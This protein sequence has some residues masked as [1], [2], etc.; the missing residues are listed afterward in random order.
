MNTNCRQSPLRPS[1]V[2]QGI[3]QHGRLFHSSV[4][5]QELYEIVSRIVRE[6]E[7]SRERKRVWNHG[8]TFHQNT[9]GQLAGMRRAT[10]GR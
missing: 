4:E 5:H 9:C 10:F 6:L 1:S 2:S 3:G 7:D 8:Q